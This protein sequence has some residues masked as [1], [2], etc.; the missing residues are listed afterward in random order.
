[1]KITTVCAHCR[2]HDIDPQIEINFRDGVVYYMC[3]ECKKESTISLK[4]E[5]KPWVKTRL[6]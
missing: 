4:A 3:P 2:N 5:N 6:R 1:M